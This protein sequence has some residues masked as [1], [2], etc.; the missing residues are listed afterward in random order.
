MRR[1]CAGRA[2]AADSAIAVGICDNRPTSSPQEAQKRLAA[3]IAAEHEGHW[4]AG[5]AI[6]ACE[7]R[8]L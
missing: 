1:A 3:E 6:A 8:P 2:S 7:L 4:I 5:V